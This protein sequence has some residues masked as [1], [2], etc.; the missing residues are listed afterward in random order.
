M[1]LAVNLKGG[2]GCLICN[3][4]KILLTELTS[5]SEIAAYHD[6]TATSLTL[7]C[8]PTSSELLQ[9]LRRS[10]S[11]DGNRGTDDIFGELLRLGRDQH[12][13]FTHRLLLVALMPALHKT[14]RIISSR[15]SLLAHDDVEQHI[16]TSTLEILQSNAL[17]TR[18]SHFAFAIAQSLRRSAFHWAI[19]EAGILAYEDIDDITESSL[20]AVPETEFPISVQL[21]TFLSGCLREGL[22]NKC[23]YE[24]L[25]SFKLHGMPA[26]QLAARQGQSEGA[27]RHRILRVVARLRG[28][29]R[30]EPHKKP[31]NV[32]QQEARRKFIA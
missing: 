22:L 12:R 29:V 18:R 10:E 19:R 2:C 3:L 4:E 28:A 5:T 25:I 9:Y 31:G 7:S 14:S 26:E 27:F 32:S 8:F 11:V 23:E 21:E 20:R 15:F 24:L 13:D 30:S 17:R 16:I 6:L 1:V